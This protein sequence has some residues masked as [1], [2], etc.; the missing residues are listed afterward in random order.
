M[1]VWNTYNIIVNGRLQWVNGKEVMT[2]N[3]GHLPFEADVT[4]FLVDGNLN[5]VT[6]AVNNTLTPYTL[7][8][9][10][11]VYPVSPVGW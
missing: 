4:T 1:T 8:P 10:D 11:I 2:H 5:R 9:G 7:P 6:A 3:G